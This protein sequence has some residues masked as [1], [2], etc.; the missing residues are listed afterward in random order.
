MENLPIIAVYGE[1]DIQKIIMTSMFHTLKASL[2]TNHNKAKVEASLSNTPPK[3]NTYA[4]LVIMYRN[5]P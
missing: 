3:S 2:S 4:R 1:Q 5:T